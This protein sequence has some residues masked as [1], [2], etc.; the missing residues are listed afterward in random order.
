MVEIVPLPCALTDTGKHGKA[1]VLHSDISNKL[2]Q[3]HGLA[4]PGTTKQ[5]DLATLGNRHDQVDNL[6]TGFQQLDRGRLFGI[7][8]RLAVDRHV[9]VS[10]YRARLVDGVT[11]H[12]HDPTQGALTHRNGDRCTGIGHAQAPADA[13]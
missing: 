2:H 3:G 6:D 13:L 10:F 12:I 1:G 7:K 5:T 9:L 4:H 11:Q 8:R